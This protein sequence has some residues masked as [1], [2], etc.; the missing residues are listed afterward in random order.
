[1]IGECLVKNGPNIT[2]FTRAHEWPH[3][4]C[5][6][7]LEPVSLLGVSLRLKDSVID[8][9]DF[10]THQNSNLLQIMFA[11]NPANST[12]QMP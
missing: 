2:G 5:V 11:G 7:W 12:K 1:M 4:I 3:F 6:F 9:V 8:V 10:G